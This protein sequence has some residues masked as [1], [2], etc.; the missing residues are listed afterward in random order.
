MKAF[1]TICV[2]FLLSSV[3]LAQQGN[4]IGNQH[5]PAGTLE[6]SRQFTGNRMLA[7]SITWHTRAPRWVMIFDTQRMPSA[8]VLTSS[9]PL[10]V[11]QFVQGAADQPQG[12][13]NYDWN[14]HPI[15]VTTGLLIVVSVNPAGCTAM[16]PDG[17]NNWIAGQMQ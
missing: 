2:W 12:T 3:A 6:S 7:A 1:I 11:C 16:T 17:P 8:G 15:I 14:F 10:I 5:T 9:A 4:V 13:Q